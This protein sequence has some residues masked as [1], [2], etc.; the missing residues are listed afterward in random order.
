[1]SKYVLE[2]KMT[3]SE[4]SKK[5]GV[6]YSTIQEYFS[7]GKDINKCA[8]G[9][10]RKIASAL[11]MTMDFLYSELTRSEK[12]ENRKY[13]GVKLPKRFAGSFW[14]RNIDSLDLDKEK[15]FVIA[16]LF[17]HA[18]FKGI[19]YVEKTFS[20]EDIIHA[21]RTRRDLNPI[22]ANFVKNRYGV[23]ECDM[24]Y[25]TLVHNDGHDWR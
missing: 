19:S 18:G 8:V 17:T 24:N 21:I 2:T 15:D 20:K 3:L 16:R 22:V 4:L 11:G 5:S 12:E 23:K 10:M 13:S 14:D 6:P 25:Y 7:E 1:M 9:T